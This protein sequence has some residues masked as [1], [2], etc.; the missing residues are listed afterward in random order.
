MAE[1]I[2]KKLFDSL[3]GAKTIQYAEYKR[4]GAGTTLIDVRSPVEFAESHLPEAV[5]IPIDELPKRC[6]E[7]NKDK[8]VVAI[9]AHGIRSAKAAKLL[10]SKG[11]KSESLLGGMSAVPDKDKVK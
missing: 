10:A 11:Y 7:I 2:I 5:N 3:S 9:C 1:S 6:E 4:S 8:K